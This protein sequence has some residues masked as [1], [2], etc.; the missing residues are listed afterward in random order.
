MIAQSRFI[1]IQSLPDQI[2]NAVIVLFAKNHPKS[3]GGGKSIR[4]SWRGER[5]K[6]KKYS[7]GDKG[8]KPS[9]AGTR[10]R[11]WRS[12]YRRNDGSRVK[13]HYVKNPNYKGK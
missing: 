10:K 5:S 9:K 2:A 7:G 6:G 8:S 11:Y 4:R 13:G 1:L 3:T 12:G